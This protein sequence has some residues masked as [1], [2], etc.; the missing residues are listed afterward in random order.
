M[1]LQK[2]NA[3]FMTLPFLY[4]WFA[5]RTVL[6]LEAGITIINY[7][8]FASIILI[9]VNHDLLLNLLLNRIRF[10]GTAQDD[11]VLTP[12]PCIFNNVHILCTSKKIC[13]EV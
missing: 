11:K 13:I 2:M 3:L 7:I 4:K 10:R 8:V 5:F 9:I 1:L 12:L 6:I